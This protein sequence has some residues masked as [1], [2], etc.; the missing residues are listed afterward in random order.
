MPQNPQ[1]HL[2][3]SGLIGTNS[4]DSKATVE[5]M[6]EDLQ[7]AATSPLP[8]GEA[9]QICEL[10]ESRG[11]RYLSFADWRKLDLLE[12]QRGEASGRIREKFTRLDEVLKA[13]DG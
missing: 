5:K 1:R 12:Q 6:V 3:P 4:P 13:L 10:L 2:R 8:D 7:G 9:E 11:V